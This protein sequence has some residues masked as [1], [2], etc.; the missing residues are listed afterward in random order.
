MVRYSSDFRILA[1][2]KLHVA[3]QK[4]REAIAVECGIGLSTLMLWKKKL[5]TQGRV[6]TNSNRKIRKKKKPLM[7]P[8]HFEYLVELIDTRPFSY[9][10]EIAEYIQNKTGKR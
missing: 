9:R 7:D 2:Q 5:K 1:L 3:G 4:N 10:R 8:C 6:F